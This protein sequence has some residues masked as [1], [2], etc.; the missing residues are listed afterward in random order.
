MSLI[1]SRPASEVWKSIG[2]ESRKKRK[3]AKKKKGAANR[4]RVELK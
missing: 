2:V 3:K 4:G 1:I